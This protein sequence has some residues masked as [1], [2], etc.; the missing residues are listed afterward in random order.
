[1]SGFY[2]GV[3]F[4]VFL[5]NRED[6]MNT[7]RLVTFWQAAMREVFELASAGTPDDKKKHRAEGFLHAL[8]MAGVLTDEEITDSIE[9]L[10]QEVFGESVKERKQRKAYLETLKNSDPDA[11]FAIPAVER[12]RV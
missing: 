9:I 6:N 7:A 2:V 3:Y 5:T 4:N 8:R 10:H 1:M 11:Y 12:K